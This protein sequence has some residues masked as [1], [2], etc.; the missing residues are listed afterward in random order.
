RL[1]YQRYDSYTETGS[2]A[3][4]TVGGRD[5][6]FS[7]INIGAI[8]AAKLGHG[9]FTASAAAVH[10]DLNGPSAV[11]ISVFGSGASLVSDVARSD[12]FGELKV[13]YEQQVGSNGTL[14]LQAQTG[15]GADSMTQAVSAFYKLTF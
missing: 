15:V 4:A 7:E 2:S 10:R 12:T 13:G 6:T 3:N 14:S 8:L 11:D 5:V 1:G 9:V